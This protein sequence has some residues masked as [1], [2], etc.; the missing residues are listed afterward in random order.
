MNMDRFTLSQEDA[1]LLVIDI[2]ERLVPAI[3]EQAS[4]LEKT[5][6][7]VQSAVA[8]SIPVLLTEQYPRGLGATVPAISDLL[9]EQLPDAQRFEKLTFNACTPEFSVALAATGRKKVIVTG[10]ETHVCV[11]QTVRQLLAEGYQVFIARDAVSSR[12]SQNRENG[13][14]LMDKMG[15]V[16]SNM[17]TIL[18]D[19][20]KVAG[21]PEF[22]QLSRLIK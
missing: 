8:L 10:M 12:T 20:L 1:V 3:F 4:I 19:L 9:A 21:T 6:V 15:A 17:E 5:L 16:I 22:K 11:F 18:F 7:L 2:Q 13:M 14:A